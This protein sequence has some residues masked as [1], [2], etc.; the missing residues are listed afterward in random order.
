M[1]LSGN[2][3]PLLYLEN[4]E[5]FSKFNH[6]IIHNITE[7]PENFNEYLTDKQHHLNYGDVDPNCGQ[8]FIDIP[9]RYQRMAYVRD[10]MA[11]GLKKAGVTDGDMVLTSDGDEIIN[12]ILLENKE[13][14][15]NPD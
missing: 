7:I 9:I 8:R 15:F 12:P 13:S 14:W 10:C 11:Y 4:K 2:T 5:R 1:T 3:T 6:K